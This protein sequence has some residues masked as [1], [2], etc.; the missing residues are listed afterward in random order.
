MNPMLKMHAP[1]VNHSDLLPP[2][3]SY[4]TAFEIP[5]QR[6]RFVGQGL[7]ISKEA[8]SSLP[9]WGCEGDAPIPRQ[10]VT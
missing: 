2:Y 10:G 5:V 6:E 7:V 9:H 1:W 4:E 3:S 8:F